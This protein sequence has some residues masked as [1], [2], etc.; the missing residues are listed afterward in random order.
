MEI[1]SGIHQIKVSMSNSPLANLNCYLIEG[2]SGWTMIDTGFHITE[3]FE[4]LKSG[5]DDIGITFSDIANI[6]VTHIHPDHFG[7][8]GR[9]KQLSPQTQLFMHR[10]ES[11]RIESR[12][13][14]FFDL[15]IQIGSMLERHG[16]PPFDA[17]KYKSAS[18]PTLEFV[19]ITFPDRTFFGGETISTGMYDLE[20]IWTPGHAIGHICIYEPKNGLLFS[21]DHILPVITPNISYHVE[22]GDNPLGDYLNALHKIENLKVSKVL[23]AHEHIFTDLKGRISEII[24]HH[25]KRKEEILKILEQNVCNA[26]DISGLLSWNIPD[27]DWESLPALQKRSA[28]METISHLQSMRWENLVKQVVKD[29]LIF[30]ALQD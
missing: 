26:Y 20:I 19:R 30:Y 16:V 13:V 1:V 22:S 6:I 8:A 17:S 24:L 14:K 10:W 7:L 4:S 27:S 18:M 12:Y 21:G 29:K 28:V 23:P 5:L 25:K 15:Q 11:D 3:S 2:R 9:I